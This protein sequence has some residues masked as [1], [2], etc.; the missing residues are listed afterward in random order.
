MSKPVR[1]VLVCINERA[2]DNP[3]GCCATKGSMDL[4]NFLKQEVAGRN[5]T[6]TIRVTKSGCL[7]P[8]EK[9]INMVVYPD[10]VWYCQVTL[11][12]A[13]EILEQHLFGD[14]PVTRL[15]MNEEEI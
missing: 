13:K 1:H 7:G 4:V 10:S 9:G 5:A 2:S 6:D 11:D 15:M 12:D 14:K 3:K 8:C